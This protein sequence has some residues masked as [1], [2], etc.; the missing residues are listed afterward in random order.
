MPHHRELTAKST[1][2]S[3]ARKEK[4]QDKDLFPRLPLAITLRETLVVM[5]LHWGELLAL[6]W[7]ILLIYSA[8][9]FAFI[10]L[11]KWFESAAGHNFA[12][13]LI[14]TEVLGLVRAGLLELL[15]IGFYAL[16]VYRLML[17]GEPLQSSKFSDPWLR[18]YAAFIGATLRA[19][20][21]PLLAFLPYILF[22]SAQAW[23]AFNGA[24]PGFVPTVFVTENWPSHA[25]RA[26]CGLAFYMLFARYVFVQVATAVDVPYRLHQS[27]C[28]TRWVWHHMLT[29]IF[30]TLGM[31]MALILALQMIWPTP[32]GALEF[33]ALG[34]AL[35]LA[36]LIWLTGV[37]GFI[38][39]LSIAFCLRTGWRPGVQN[40]STPHTAP[41]KDPRA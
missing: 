15:L 29:I 23:W 9:S 27:W 5:R 37:T 12:L 36:C 31:A 16:A 10:L 3:K 38:V 11:Q 19:M 39:A 25:I 40:L 6:A 41:S 18:R 33:I 32:E 28:I 4:P 30:L 34:S 20:A 1:P 26:I 22:I 35:I 21:L 14:Q 7:L 17:L 8:F 13:Y 24:I 2:P